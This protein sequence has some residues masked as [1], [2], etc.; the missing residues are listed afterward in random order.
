MAPNAS[1]CL[2]LLVSIA[3]ASAFQAPAPRTHYG[4]GHALERARSP[5]AA[6]HTTRVLRTFA[7]VPA[8]HVMSAVV[9]DFAQPVAV[10]RRP[11]YSSMSR[12][13]LLGGA[14]FLAVMKV[15]Q[16]GAAAAPASWTLLA[17]ACAGALGGLAALAGD[18][19][20]FGSRRAYKAL[21]ES[22]KFTAITKAVNSVTFAYIQQAMA[23]LGSGGIVLAAA[24]TGVVATLVQQLFAGSSPGFFQDNV[25]R[26]VFV[27]EAFWLTYAGLCAL[28]PAMSISY[29]GIAISGA[30]SGIASTMVASVKFTG[31]GSRGI[32]QRVRH[33]CAAVRTAFKSAEFSRA[34]VQSGILF[35]VYQA[36]FNTLAV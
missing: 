28:S 14:L 33:G 35:V 4:N 29:T 7:P 19:A 20:F 6:R 36:V 2:L 32:F 5:H 15:Y 11:P 30:L 25:W 26:N 18:S 9:L 1:S 23:T 22:I 16:V 13:S 3:C 27:F 12:S 10:Q 31:R 24:G 8:A 34:A 17:H 21:L